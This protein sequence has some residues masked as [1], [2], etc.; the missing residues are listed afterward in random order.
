MKTLLIIFMILFVVVSI[1]S[2]GDG[3][4][5]SKTPVKDP[6]VERVILEDKVKDLVRSALK[7]PDSAKFGNITYT[8]G[9]IC[10]NVNSKNSFGGYGGMREFMVTKDRLTF[11]DGG[12][13]FRKAW[14]AK[15]AG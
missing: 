11:N 8:K 1:A 10:G 6:Y 14:N 13:E 7:D 12:A 3:K 4:N 15:C 9:V 5:K 2:M